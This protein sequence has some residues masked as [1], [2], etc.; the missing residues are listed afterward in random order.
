ME[1]NRYELH[2]PT[3]A[4]LAGAIYDDNLFRIAE[5]TNFLLNNGYTAE[6]LDKEIE[7]QFDNRFRKNPY[8]Y[9]RY[10]K[11]Y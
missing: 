9:R 3:P 1:N 5:E 7:T 2:K 8:R 10:K 4:S 6:E 11:T